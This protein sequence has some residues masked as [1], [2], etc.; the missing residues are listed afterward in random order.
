MAIRSDREY[1]SFQAPVH[2]L[3]QEDGQ[4]KR[5]IVEGYASTYA[6]YTLFSEDGV[7]YREQIMPG[8]FDASDMSDVI[9]LYDHEGMVYARSRNGSLKIDADE[10]GLHIIADLGG[11]SESRKMYEQIA[12]GLVDQMSF[13]FTVKDCD[14]EHTEGACTRKIVSVKKVYDVSAVSIP[15]NPGT[16]IE[17][18]SQRAAFNGEIERIK[19][20]RLERERRLDLAK[21]KYNFLK[22]KGE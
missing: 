4:E 22:R 19:T 18:V 12:S 15:A 16:D 7:D 13:A 1:R 21:A 10:K 8:A 6:P 5:Y 17:A 20:E 11:T 3:S 14:Y 2:V 9:F